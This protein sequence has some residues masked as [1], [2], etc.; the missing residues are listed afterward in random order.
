MEA[1]SHDACGSVD[2]ML[3]YKL[4]TAIIHERYPANTSN[5]EAEIHKYLYLSTE[6][7][8]VIR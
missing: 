4:K 8:I 1:V 2:S 6:S 7:D 5:F 3:G